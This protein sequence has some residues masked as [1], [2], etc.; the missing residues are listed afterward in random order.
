MMKMK[1]L[2]SSKICVKLAKLTTS[3]ITSQIPT[4]EITIMQII[5]RITTQ[6]ISV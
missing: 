4:Q 3:I 1:M 6:K 5:L 2:I